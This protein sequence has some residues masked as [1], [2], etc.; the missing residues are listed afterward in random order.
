MVEMVRRLSY[1]LIPM[2]L[3][4]CGPAAVQPPPARPT[5]PPGAVILGDTPP[6]DELIPDN[7]EVADE[8]A[9]QPDEIAPPPAVERPPHPL[10]DKTDSELE[11]L[12]LKDPDSLGS[13]AIG[14]PHSG[15]LFNGV[16][17][18]E[19]EHWTIVNPRETWGTTETVEFI[20]RAIDRVNQEFPNSEKLRIGDISIRTGGHLAP[21]LSHQAGRDVDLGFYYTTPSQ[22]Y[23]AANASNL[24]LARTWALIRALVTET[25]VQLILL[26]RKLQKLLRAY[27]EEIGEDPGWL[28]QLFGGPS[29]RLRPLIRHAEGHGTHL[30]VRFYNP[31]AQETG[32]RLYPM[33]IAHKMI[34]PPTYYAKYKVRSGDTL[35][36]LADK[37][38]TSVRAIKRANGLRSNRIFAN[39]VYKIPRRGGVRQPS[40]PL[41]IPARRL[42]PRPPIPP[43]PTNLTDVT[44]R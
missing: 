40:G 30:H 39:R 29:T 32:R 19:S 41:V 35:G 1:L 33:L 36:R 25:D 14:A 9:P 26:D 4:A 13:A 44:A 43:A 23:M 31:I 10:A 7:D 8:V 28:D 17:M 22:W 24:D 42:P 2:I 27:A 11:E 38:H 3:Q 16:P 5:G 18:P 37:F 34:S 6:P 12:L 15:A 21:H 20:A